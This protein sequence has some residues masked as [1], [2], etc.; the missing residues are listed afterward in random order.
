MALH[1]RIA[2]NAPD[3]IRQKM[4]VPELLPR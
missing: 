1:Y 4:V 2:G 3:G